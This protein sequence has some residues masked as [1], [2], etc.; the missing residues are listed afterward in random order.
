MLSLVLIGP[1]VR[2]VIGNRQTDKQTYR[3]LYVRLTAL[4]LA[5]Q[6]STLER[7]RFDKEWEI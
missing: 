5:F 2:P 1:V 4:F 6:D 3:L 7:S